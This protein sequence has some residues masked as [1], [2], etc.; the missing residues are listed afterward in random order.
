MQFLWCSKR[1]KR[2]QRH[3][4][5][6][7]A[8]SLNYSRHET[9]D[10]FSRCDQRMCMDDG[11]CVILVVSSCAPSRWRRVSTWELFEEVN[12][13]CKGPTLR[14]SRATEQLSRATWSLQRIIWS[15]PVVHYDQMISLTCLQNASLVTS[16]SFEAQKGSHVTS[17][18]MATGN[19]W[20]KMSQAMQRL[21]VLKVFNHS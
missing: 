3:A 16:T 6:F 13:W 18:E 7:L 11:S 20:V 19:S 2:D 21:E 4:A 12:D 15:G 9:W 10:K 17:V 8:R 14:N 5:C 1:I